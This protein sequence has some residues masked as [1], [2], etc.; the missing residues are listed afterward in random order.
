MIH[1]PVFYRLPDVTLSYIL[2]F[3]VAS[4]RIYQPDKMIDLGISCD[5]EEITLIV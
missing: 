1:K 2:G 3:A 5:T 4:V